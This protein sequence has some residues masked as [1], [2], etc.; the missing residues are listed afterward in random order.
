ML[1]VTESRETC[2]S[3]PG[4]T[5]AL[6]PSVWVVRRFPGLR[7]DGRADS[8]IVTQHGSCGGEGANHPNTVGRGNRNG[9]W[10][11]DTERGRRY[12]NALNPP[13]KSP[14]RADTNLHHPGE[15][16]EAQKGHLTEEHASDKWGTRDSNPGHLTA[17]TPLPNMLSPSW[18]QAWDKQGTS[19]GQAGDSREWS[20]PE[21][22]RCC[23]SFG[24]VGER[25]LYPQLY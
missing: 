16:T 4:E 25:R 11:A 6:A 21:A 22:S 20:E 9:R 24:L 2:H 18:R 15:E 7:A 1:E 23:F 8:N 12:L 5:Q 3:G 14:L 10:W 17:G 13:L 19:R